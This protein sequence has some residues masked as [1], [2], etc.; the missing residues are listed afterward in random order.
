MAEH[1]DAA[2]HR[3]A[4]VIPGLR[5]HAARAI[6]NAA[7]RLGADKVGVVVDCDEEG[8]DGN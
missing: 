8:V 3:V 2:A 5:E 1:I 7:G 6:C 4:V